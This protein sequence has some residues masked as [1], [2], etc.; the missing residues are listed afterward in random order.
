MEL[1][2]RAGVGVEEMKRHDVQVVI[3]IPPTRERAS[4]T[5]AIVMDKR[6]MPFVTSFAAARRRRMRTLP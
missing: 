4:Q 2:D 3:L 1:L 5:A 6:G